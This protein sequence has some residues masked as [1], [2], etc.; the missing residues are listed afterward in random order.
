[1][2]D[3]R[4][5][6]VR[7]DVLQVKFGHLDDVDNPVGAQQDTVM[8]RDWRS[9]DQLAKPVPNQFEQFLEGDPARG[10]AR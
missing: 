5:Q 9:Y 1:M 2:I 4:D 6:R 10:L 3:K 8:E 7:E